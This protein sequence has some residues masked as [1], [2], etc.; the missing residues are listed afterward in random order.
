M[1][2]FDIYLVIAA[3]VLGAGITA[4]MRV[5]AQRAD[6]LD[7]PNQRSSHL[8][9][10]PR[11][12]GL[13]I[14]IVF[15]GALI[16]LNVF[17]KLPTDAFSSLLV[18]GVLVAGI[19]FADDHGHIP[20]KW[21]FL[22]QIIAATIAVAILGGLPDIRLGD[23]VVDL[24]PLGDAMAVVFTVWFVNLYNFMDGIDGIAAVE[25]VCIAGSALV[26]ASV[27]DSGFVSSLL[28]VFAATVLGFLVWNWP[29]AKIFMGDVGSGFVGFVLA[30]L[31]IIS[32]N[33]GVLPIWCWL[34]LAGVFV[35][36]ATIT[37]VTRMVNGEEWYAAHNSHAYQKASRRLKG[38][39][40]VTLAVFAI[41]VLW[42]LP[43]AW[44]AAAHPE[45]GWW[46]TAAAWTPLIFLSLFLKAGRPE[47]PGA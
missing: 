12:G 40:P 43:I 20:A 36:D 1:R 31:A 15:V 14:V 21:R 33:L 11:G 45:F 3:F 34:I 9:A 30:V 37:L 25:A 24:G 38:H 4:L 18:G 29:P 5:Y 17:G 27:G 8:V 26:I 19:G 46:L 2:S 23:H 16:C 22:V 44:L 6:L 10:T 32:G 47:Q 13:S 42:L 7:V 39:R 35:V 28:V 41:N